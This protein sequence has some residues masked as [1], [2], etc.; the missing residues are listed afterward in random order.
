[1]KIA[2][3]GTK[4]YDREFFEKFN[5]EGLFNHQVTYF[6]ARLNEQTVSSL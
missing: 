2:F 4:G 6:E 3:F 1:M 5:A